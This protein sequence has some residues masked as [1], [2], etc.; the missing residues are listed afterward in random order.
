M[1]STILIF[2]AFL[3]IKMPKSFPN[4]L[5]SFEALPPI[6]L[7]S[8]SSKIFSTRILP[9]FPVAPEISIAHFLFIYFQK[10]T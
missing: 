6:R 1:L 7:R 5:L 2:M 9:T 10:K 8:E 4:S 3:P